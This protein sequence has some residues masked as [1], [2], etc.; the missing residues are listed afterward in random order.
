MPEH[1]H[2]IRWININKH[3]FTKKVCQT[4]KVIHLVTDAIT[5][6]VNIYSH[7]HTNTSLGIKERSK[8]CFKCS[9]FPNSLAN[10]RARTRTRTHK[11][12]KQTLDLCMMRVEQ[13]TNSIIKSKVS[14][15]IITHH[16]MLE[17]TKGKSDKYHVENFHSISIRK[18][19]DSVAYRFHLWNP[20]IGQRRSIADARNEKCSN[21]MGHFVTMTRLRT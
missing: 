10:T 12:R 7:T 11:I 18:K 3:G 20:I 14:G 21:V 4:E 1:T 16:R 5:R 19:S 2:R 9:S 13:R 6:R 8:G 15:F 17:R